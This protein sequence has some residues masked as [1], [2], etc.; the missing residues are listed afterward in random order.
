MGPCHWHRHALGLVAAVELEVRG[1]VSRATPHP[2]AQ[3]VRA[4]REAA[5]HLRGLHEVVIG[6]PV[7]QPKVIVEMP[8]PLGKIGFDDASTLP[9]SGCRHTGTVSVEAGI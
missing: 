7:R 5:N 2:S 3:R 9:P 6:A 8:T 4:A 1:I